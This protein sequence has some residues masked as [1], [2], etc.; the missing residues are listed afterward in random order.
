MQSIRFK[1]HFLSV[2]LLEHFNFLDF[3]NI[4][5]LI[6]YDKLKML[7]HVHLHHFL[8]THHMLWSRLLK[9][10]LYIWTHQIH[11]IYAYLWFSFLARLLMRG[12]HRGKFLPANTK[13]TTLVS[14]KI[15]CIQ[16]FFFFFS[17]LHCLIRI[18]FKI[19]IALQFDSNNE[20]RL[21]WSLSLSTVNHL[22]LWWKIC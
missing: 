14:T 3:I 20:N 17:A 13:W 4:I 5:L 8:M 6:F 19:D 10:M 9:S 11:I 18:V 12:W 21:K 22:K 2:V 15:T 7:T 1:L 16:A